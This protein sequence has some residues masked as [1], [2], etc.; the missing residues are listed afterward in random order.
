M[1]TV[2]E[3]SQ[4]E[5]PNLAPPND[6]VVKS[7]IREDATPWIEYAVQQFMIYQKTLEESI[8]SAI[9]T[10]RSRL[11]QIRLTAS[12]HFHQTIVNF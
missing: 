10:S 9:Q 6:I 3:S 1:A 2:A 12:A 7:K 4:G 8:D 11:S 5:N